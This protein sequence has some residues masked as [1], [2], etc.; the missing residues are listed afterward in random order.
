MAFL[1]G[2]RAVLEHPDAA[3]A[4]RC[5]RLKIEMGDQYISGDVRRFSPRPNL[6]IYL[7]CRDEWF[8]RRGIYGDGERD[9]E[10][11]FHRFLF[12]QKS[13]I[14]TIRLLTLGADILHCHEWQTGLLPLLLRDAEKRFEL[15]LAVTTV[16][17][18]HNIAFQGLFRCARITAPICPTSSGAS[19]AWSSTASSA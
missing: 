5:L 6:T 7:I 17:T 18:I 4:K 15:T 3:Q 16:F 13:V 1:P 10:D 14:E 12:F 9:Y 19:T 8:D 2:Y 11:N